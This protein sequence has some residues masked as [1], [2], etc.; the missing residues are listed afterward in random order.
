[1]GVGVPNFTRTGRPAPRAIC[2]AGITACGPD[3]S[4]S[5]RDRLQHHQAGIVLE[6]SVAVLRRS[7]HQ[8]AHKVLGASIWVFPRD[9]N[10]I[11]FAEGLIVEVGRLDQ[12]VG[13]ND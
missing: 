11:L 3:G 1:M 6:A 9:A 8:R 7:S 12:A 13:E 4:M 5:V 2:S 10:Y